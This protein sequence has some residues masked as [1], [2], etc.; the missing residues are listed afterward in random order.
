[1]SL[2]GCMCLFSLGMIIC[3]KAE[4]SIYYGV[5]KLCQICFTYP[6]TRNFLAVLGGPYL[7]IY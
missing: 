2:I 7:K 3:S 1:M 5:T 6:R 4:G